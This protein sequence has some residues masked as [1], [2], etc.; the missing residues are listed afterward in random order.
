MSA[1]VNVS[2]RG[3]LA[4]GMAAGACLVLGCSVSPQQVPAG[5]AAPKPLP[6]PQSAPP[7]ASFAP[8]AFLR[9]DSDD[10]VTLWMTKPEMGQGTHTSL[11]MLIAEELEVDWTSI[12]FER[13]DFDPKYLNQSVVGSSSI[14]KNFLPLRRLGASARAMLIAAAAARWKVAADS[15]RAERGSVVHPPSGQTL[16]Y[17]QLV[18]AAAALPVPAESDVPL[19]DPADFKIIGTRLPRVDSPAKIDGT[20]AY[21]ADVRLPGM[22]FATVVHCPVFGGKIGSVDPADA[23][24][25]PGVRRVLELPPHTVAVVADSTWTAMKGAQ[26]LRVNWDEGPHAKLDSARIARLLADRAR[27]AAATG[28]KEGD[29]ARALSGAAKKLS[30]SYELPFQAHASMEPMSGTA[31]VRKDGCDVWASM[32]MP[33]M[34]VKEIKELTGLG[35]DAI[36]IHIP[37][38]GGGFGRRAE[39]DV[40]VQAIKLSKEMGAPV[41]LVWSREE[42]IQHDVYRPASH[43]HLSAGL[44]A[45]GRLVA[46]THRIVAP[47]I[48]AQRGWTKGPLD[49]M[50]LEGAE[51]SYAIPH[52]LV[53]YAMANTAIPIGFWRSVY[54]SQN[55]FANECF[56]DELARLAGKDAV[57]LR[58]ELLASAPRLK[59]VL[60]LAAEKAGWGTPLAPGKGRGIA[61]HASFGSFLAQVAEVSVAA[62]GEVK[63]DRVVCAIDC[64][65][66]VHPVSVEAQVE[67]AIVYG[68]SAALKAEITIDK[69]RVV[70]GNFD[71]YPVPRMRDAPAIEVHIVPSRESPGG[72]G[73]PGLP[74]IAPAVVNAIFAATG[75]RIRRLPIRAAELRR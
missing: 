28:H 58:R 47:S 19:K 30:A 17:G 26:A 34:L 3:F 33:E 22:L 13:T 66:A 59:A 49:Q 50:A 15:C 69:G 40:P 62:D 48:A 9:I 42:D 55:A 44:D 43:H 2:R 23:M 5:A 51:I 37:Y 71:D 36:R 46:W 56:L 65:V 31:D 53:E 38:L 6:T 29:A 45:A 52:V 67:S 1:V 74:P 39:S 8:N 68:L 73:E 27:D 72:L 63:V 70:Q 18:E 7:T 16:R 75:K 54:N 25:I 10:K 21:G 61:T 12:H 35:A 11:P 4:G 24:K 20:A 14:R 60:D 57:A 64:G 41:Q 32:Q